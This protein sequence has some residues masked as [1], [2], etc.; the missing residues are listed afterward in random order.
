AERCAEQ[1]S[2]LADELVLVLRPGEEGLEVRAQMSVAQP[3]DLR[4]RL[5]LPARVELED[6]TD[7]REA[8][9]RDDA[10]GDRRFPEFPPGVREA[11]NFGGYG[12]LAVIVGWLVLR[13]AKQR[14]VD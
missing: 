4:R 8:F 7:A 2:L 3:R 9:T 6:P 12:V 11:P 14:V 10:L 1:T 5:V 13:L